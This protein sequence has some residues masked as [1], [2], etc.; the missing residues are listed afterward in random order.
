MSKLSV[1][2]S[3]TRTIRKT[4]KAFLEAK[5]LL[6]TV[7]G[8]IVN[9]GDNVEFEKWINRELNGVSDVVK[10]AMWF[11]FWGDTGPYEDTFVVR[12]SNT[13]LLSLSRKRK[14]KSARSSFMSML[15]TKLGGDPGNAIANAFIKPDPDK[16]KE[17]MDTVVDSMAKAIDRTPPVVESSSILMKGKASAK[18]EAL[19]GQVHLKS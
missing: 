18:R 12:S 19:K 14:H 2:L 6:S 13:K 10:A 9:D 16:F 1:S 15:M 17:L 3:G 5:K 11:L 7:P 8:H 4:D